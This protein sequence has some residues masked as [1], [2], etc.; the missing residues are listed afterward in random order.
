MVATQSASAGRLLFLGDI[1]FKGVNFASDIF[2]NVKEELAAADIVFANLECCLSLGRAVAPRQAFCADPWFG[3]VLADAGI[4]IVGNANNVNFGSEAI[5]VSNQVLDEAGVLHVGSGANIED[6]SGAKILVR[7]GR[8][9]GFLQR[10]AIYWPSGHEA[11][12]N[13]AGVAILKAHTGYRP[14]LDHHAAVTR[15]GVPP[16]VITWADKHALEKLQ[17][18]VS[19]LR[20][21]VDF[22]TASFHWGY[23]QDVL[24]YQK[25][26]AH[27][28]IDAGADLVFGHGPHTIAPLERYKNKMI[29][30]GMGNFVFHV[31]HTEDV[32]AHWTGM[33]ARLGVAENGIHSIDL[34][35]VSKSEN[36][37]PMLVPY[38]SCAEEF[39]FLVTTSAANGVS[40]RETYDAIWFRAIC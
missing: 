36:N 15:P 20:K 2:D 32:H 14:V 4:D 35:F 17:N 7:D 19:K 28:A 1:N 34:A 38:R 18:E 22:L 31:A 33:I 8:R 12:T 6:A 3:S 25:E 26:F 16:E 27:A 29:I 24:A 37:Q 5:T 30:Y 23:R 10:T 39:K 40:I 21:E 11:E 9:Y 13:Q